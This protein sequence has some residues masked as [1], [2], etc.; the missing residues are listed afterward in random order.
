MPSDDD[1]RR[2]SEWAANVVIV[3]VCI[4]WAASFLA[5]IFHPTFKPPTEVNIA[6]GGVVGATLGIRV[7]KER[8]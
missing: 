7:W 3:T 2:F 6:F 1:G 4:V 8:P 5:T